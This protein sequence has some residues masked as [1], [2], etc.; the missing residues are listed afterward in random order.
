MAST[1]LGSMVR[2]KASVKH[3]VSKDQ[4]TCVLLI[5]FILFFH[6]LETLCGGLDYAAFGAI[7]PIS[8]GD[9][10]G[11][12]DGWTRLGPYDSALPK[13]RQKQ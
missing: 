10:P 1:L 5:L 11:G 4:T 13:P 8:S 7:F 9:H 12:Q 2:I 6:S 3:E